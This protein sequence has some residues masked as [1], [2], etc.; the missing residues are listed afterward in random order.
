MRPDESTE[1]IH[2]QEDDLTKISIPLLGELA[3]K[4]AVATLA[5]LAHPI[6]GSGDPLYPDIFW[7]S[8]G[9]T[10]SNPTP[11]KGD[12][13]IITAEVTNAGAHPC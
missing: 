1:Y 11:T 10:V 8:E 13:V 9:I 2:S 12:E 3:I 4:L 7:E 6:V 5:E